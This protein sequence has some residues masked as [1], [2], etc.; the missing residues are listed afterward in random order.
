MSSYWH[1]K[2]C[3]V[4]GGLGCIGSALTQALLDAGAEVDV[5]DPAVEQPDATA[6]FAQQRKLHIHH[7]DVRTPA[8]LA[9]LLPQQQHI[10]NLI[11]Q[12]GHLHSLQHPNADLDANF[13]AP[14]ALLQAAH[15]YAPRVVHVLASSR[16]VYGRPRYLPVDELHPCA[17]IDLNAVHRLASEQHYQIYAQSHDMP[18]RILRFGNVLSTTLL[19]RDARHSFLAAWLAALR[20]GRPFEV[21]G[22]EQER[23][24]LDVSDAVSA[25]LCAAQAQCSPGRIFN[26]SGAEP[27]SLLALADRLIGIAREGS[28]CVKAMPPQAGQI[29]LGSF[30]TNIARARREIDW[31]PSIALEEILQRIVR[32]RNQQYELAS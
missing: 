12:A 10:F 18:I 27:I 16:Q 20:A 14:I 4:A 23:E 9:Q 31:Q 2:R 25:L 5:I 8:L 17:P 22:G 15:K 32:A 29:E 1:D 24:L 19:V 28:Y 30:R 13:L 26:I 11:G 3:L 6:L 7:C 21:W